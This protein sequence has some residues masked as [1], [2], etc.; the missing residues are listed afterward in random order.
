M[1]NLNMVRFMFAGHAV[2]FPLPDI[3]EL[4][5]LLVF[6]LLWRPLSL[7][8][9]MTMM[10]MKR[11]LAPCHCLVEPRSYHAMPC[12]STCWVIHDGK[13]Q[14]VACLVSLQG[15]ASP[16]SL[17]SCYTACSTSF[18]SPPTCH[19]AAATSSSTSSSNSASSTSSHA[20]GPRIPLPIAAPSIP[21]CATCANCASASGCVCQTGTAGDELASQV[22][23][24]LRDKKGSHVCGI[25]MWACGCSF[26]FLVSNLSCSKAE[27]YLQ[28]NL[29][30]YCLYF[31]LHSQRCARP[32]VA[33]TAGSEPLGGGNF[34]N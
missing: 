15:K 27:T 9:M 17:E 7:M 13:L 10:N 4:G 5:G 1:L 25:C 22:S 6:S 12:L 18:S 8:T 2:R 23:T 19:L 21:S 33:T 3:M 26:G 16:P 14:H 34:A 24:V 32:L 29:E 28:M 20:S 30:I 11:T 31:R